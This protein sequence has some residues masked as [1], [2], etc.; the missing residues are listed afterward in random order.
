MNF[1]RTFL[2]TLSLLCGLITGCGFHCGRGAL[3]ARY[4]TIS[5]PYAEGDRDGDLTKELVRAISR[6][7]AFEYRK[8]NGELTLR[9][10]I[11]ASRKDSIGFRFDLDETSTLTERLV[12]GEGRLVALV[13]VQLIER[14]TG[15]IVFGPHVVSASTDFDHDYFGTPMRAPSFS[16][17]QLDALDV[18]MEAAKKPLNRAVA[19]R[20]LELVTGEWRDDLMEPGV[21]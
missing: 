1:H 6:S 15:K 14:A 8:E 16:L 18:A 19:K 5:I 13:E 9:V 7:G 10:A 2:I 4:P 3:S 20:V 17:G 12:P 21:S 11:R